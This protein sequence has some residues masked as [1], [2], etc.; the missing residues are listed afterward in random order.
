VSF[1]LCDSAALDPEAPFQVR[2]PS[3]R[4]VAVYKVGEQIFVTDD[5][6]THGEA[7]LAEGQL[8]GYEVECPYHMGRF[9]IRTGEPTLAPC[10]EPVRIYP[11]SIIDGGVYISLGE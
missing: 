10:R 1:F 4:F 5:L 6:C 8:D 11:V 2:L 9:D 3:G 7:S